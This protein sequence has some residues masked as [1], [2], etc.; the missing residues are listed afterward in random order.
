MIGFGEPR[1]GDNYAAYPVKS[2]N[3]EQEWHG[4]RISSGGAKLFRCEMQ[5][6]ELLVD[7]S[8]TLPAIEIRRQQSTIVTAFGLCAL[9]GLRHAAFSSLPSLSSSSS[10]TSMKTAFQKLRITDGIDI[11]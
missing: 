9:V 10:S 7:R 4:L 8:P 3:V 1:I 2:K 11:I 6:S 5:Q